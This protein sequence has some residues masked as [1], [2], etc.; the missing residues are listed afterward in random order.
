LTIL[1]SPNSKY[2]DYLKDNID[3]NQVMAYY[4]FNIDPN[5]IPYMKS[6]K[7]FISKVKS[8]EEW[9]LENP[10][11]IVGVWFKKENYQRFYKQKD[12]AI[13]HYNNY[14]RKRSMDMDIMLPE[15]NNKEVYSWSIYSINQAISQIREIIRH[16]LGH[17]IQDVLLITNT[18]KTR[19]ENIASGR[20]TINYGVNSKRLTKDNQRDMTDWKDTAHHL[21]DIEFYPNIE[22]NLNNIRQELKYYNKPKDRL[23][24][25]KEIISN[26][27]IK[28]ENLPKYKKMVNMLYKTLKK[29]GFF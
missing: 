9:G 6:K 22:T 23:K 8:N 18:N 3:R 14:T 5:D 19:E 7:D 2:F 15:L 17:F 26:Y 21:R 16:E 13:G 1:S 10:K 4:E 29:E 27:Q 12:I 28:N 25:F 11:F 20:S 24:K